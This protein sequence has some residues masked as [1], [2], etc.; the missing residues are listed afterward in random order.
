[1]PP[2]SPNTHLLTVKSPLPPN[3]ATATTNSIPIKANHNF[4][5]LTH[6]PFVVL[7]CDSNDPHHKT[8]SFISIFFK[9]KPNLSLLCSHQPLQ[10]KIQ[11]TKASHHTSSSN[12]PTFNPHCKPLI[13]S[14]QNAS[15]LHH[16]SPKN[17]PKAIVSCPH[18]PVQHHL[19]S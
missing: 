14:P 5:F 10:P 15:L 19:P 2:K 8:I 18:N 13:P 4:L 12:K 1:V 17:K 16:P 6:C 9:A 3:S 7:H 11:K